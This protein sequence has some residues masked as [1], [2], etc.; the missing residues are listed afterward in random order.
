M[1]NE[2]RCLLA[3]AWIRP[4]LAGVALRL[5]VLKPDAN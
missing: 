4:R 3:L 1:W 2:K 5:T